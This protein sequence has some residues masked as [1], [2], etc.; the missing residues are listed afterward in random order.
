MDAFVSGIT[1]GQKRKKENMV[2]LNQHM[3]PSPSVAGANRWPGLESLA[4]FLCTV[5]YE[6]WRFIS[7]SVAW[8]PEDLRFDRTHVQIKELE[9]GLLVAHMEGSSRKSLTKGDV[10]GLLAGYPLWYREFL[11]TP[12]GPSVPYP[13]TSP[14][15]I[16]RVGWVVA[17][18]LSDVEPL[19]AV[20]HNGAHKEKPIIRTYDIPK[21]PGSQ[22][23]FAMGLFNEPPNVPLSPEQMAMLRPI[24][25]PVVDAA[26]RGAC[27]VVSL[28]KNQCGLAFYWPKLLRDPNRRGVH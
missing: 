11:R 28:S 26:F 6:P 21:L 24:H 18:G 5:D 19:A 15:D 7:P 16:N 1:A 10:E 22:A 23:T 14:D 8:S 25:L 4:F 13:I 27:K 3:F 17:V 9:G 2:S 12:H 20:P